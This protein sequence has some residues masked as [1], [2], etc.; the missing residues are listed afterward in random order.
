MYEYNLSN[1]YFV[2]YPRSGLN[3]FAEYFEQST[4]H[5]LPRSHSYDDDFKGETFTIVRDPLETIVS[6]SSMF[7]SFN[8]DRD[9]PGITDY[10]ANAYYKFYNNIINKK[11]NN[12]ISY[13]S[14]IENPKDIQEKFIKHLGMQYFDVKYTNYLKPHDDYI[15]TSKETK[16]YEEVLKY[17]K[18]LD[19]SAQ[20]TEYAIALEKDLFKHQ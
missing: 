13:K 12:V 3:Y 10:V 2:T 5:R 1:V 15:V 19:L 8:E 14:F 7:L 9:V 4:G 11:I 17:A 18:T 16:Q 6:H 20:Y